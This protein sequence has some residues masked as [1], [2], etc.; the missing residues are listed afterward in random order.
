[1][2][3]PPPHVTLADAQ[4]AIAEAAKAIRNRDEVCRA[5]AHQ[6]C[7]HKIGDIV[8]KKYERVRVQVITYEIG[9]QG[10]L[11]WRVEGP[12]VTKAGDNHKHRLPTYLRGKP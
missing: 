3:R 7:P 9:W 1:M 10:E 2:S 6:A 8:D 4:H 5:W 11:Y 12:V